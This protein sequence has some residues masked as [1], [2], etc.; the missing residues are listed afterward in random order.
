MVEKDKI[1]IKQFKSGSSDF[2][3]DY[4]H[5][6]LNEKGEI[7]FCAGGLDTEEKRVALLAYIKR[8]KK[9]FKKSELSIFDTEEKEYSTISYG[10]YN[11]LSTQMIVAQDKSYAKWL[12]ENSREVKIKEEIKE[13]LKIK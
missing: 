4:V 7:N 3:V 10:K 8:N 6:N 5:Y 12:Y 13:L 9:V 1:T 11:G 2:W